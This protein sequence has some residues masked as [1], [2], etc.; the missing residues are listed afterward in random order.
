MIQFIDSS[1]ACQIT[2]AII[3]PTQPMITDTLAMCT[4]AVMSASHSGSMVMQSYDYSLFLVT[5]Q[6]FE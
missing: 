5:L 1:T 6:L 3:I 2:Q 4:S